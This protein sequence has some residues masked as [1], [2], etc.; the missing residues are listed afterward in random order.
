MI[1]NRKDK[2]YILCAAWKR[3]FPRVVDSKP[4]KVKNDI[5]EIEI[6]YRHHDIFLRFGDELL[7]EQSAMGFYTS[8]GR[9]VNREEGMEIAINCGQVNKEN[10]KWTEKDTKDTWLPLDEKYIGRY[11][12]LMSEDLY[13]CSP[14]YNDMNE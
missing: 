10:P 3:K 6:G 4:Y 1:D 5:L 2:E 8:H 7:Q 14:D 9:F 12:P 13:T 11:K